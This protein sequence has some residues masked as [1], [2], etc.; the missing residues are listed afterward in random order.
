MR[1]HEDDVVTVQGEARLGT[2][3]AKG[4][5]VRPSLEVTASHVL[6]LRQPK[7]AKTPDYTF[8][9]E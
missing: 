1:L 6:A 9:V 5:D 3:T 7:S 4:G 8:S 2:Y